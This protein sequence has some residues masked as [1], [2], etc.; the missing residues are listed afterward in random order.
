MK[1]HLPLLAVLALIV[2]LSLLG[3][4][5][6]LRV[7]RGSLVPVPTAT[8]TPTPTATVTP[9]PADTPTSTATATSTV[10]PTP[11]CVPDAKFISDITVP[12]G[13]TFLPGEPIHKIWRMKNT[14][15]CSWGEGYNWVFVRGDR[16]EAT[17]IQ[18]APSASPGEEANIE[19]RLRAPYVEGIYKSVWQM[20]APSGQLFGEVAYVWIKVELPETPSPTH[21]SQGSKLTKCREK[22]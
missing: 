12:D 11:T 21:E 7:R 10:T 3:G 9:T 8:A 2:S 1:S 19:L 6:L 20:R 16:L 13:S 5:A 22:V 14:G 4:A 18:E 17:P 15:T